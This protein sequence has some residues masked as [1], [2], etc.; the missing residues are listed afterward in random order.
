MSLIDRKTKL[1]ARRMIRHQKRLAESV[2][3]QADEE[4]NRLF[5][6]RFG[7]LHV[8]R[9]FVLVWTVLVLLLGLGAL[10]QVRGLN[11]FYLAAAPID[12]GVYREGIIGTFTNANPLFATTSVDTSVSK[13]IFSGLFK[14]S[15][16]G[17]LTGDLAEKLD[18]DSRGITYTVTL[19]DGVYW[20]DGEK[21]TADDVV[22]TY[23]TIQ[24]PAAR[25][26]LRSNWQGVKVTKY[27]DKIVVFTLPSPLSSF[28]Y[29]LINGIVPEHILG[30]VDNEDLRSSNFNT[31]KPIGTGMFQLKTLEVSGVEID[32]RQERIALVRNEG[33]FGR[34]PGLDSV[35]IR[36]YRDEETMIK[37]FD[38]QIIKSMVGLN[39]VPDT[40]QNQETVTLQQAPLTSTV[41]VFL[42]N[43][44]KL[45]QDKKLRQ[46]LLYAT[47]SDSMRK[48]L[49]YN[50]VA[51]D[52]P[53]LKNQ[54]A[55]N[56]E[57]VQMPYDNVKAT[58]LL[59]ELGW[60]MESDGIRAKDGVKLSL[61]F[62]SQSLSEYASITQK[63]QQDWSM[64]GISIEAILQPEAD[65]QVNALARH[66][67]DVFLYGISIG[68]DPDVFA[69]W[70]SS[71]AD[72]NS[73]SLNLSEYK[74][75]T[76]DIALEAGRTRLDKDLRKV[77]YQPFLEHW[78]DDAP[79]KA[80]YQPRFFMVTRGTFVG[81]ENG[82]MSSATD[83]Y[84]S[85]AD[86]KIRNADVIK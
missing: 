27:D 41:M 1:K 65:I 49:S 42:N 32:S 16:N 19:R 62:V 55:Y 63:L 51:S 5:F 28:S 45:L 15:G 36:S 71:Q 13:L 66:D 79:A 7:R 43:S 50:A 44:S 8:V 33:Y 29:S 74:D 86:W 58:A 18:V 77:K 6:R 9:R 76:S 40:L 64:L 10:W 69:Y 31:V 81:F 82:Y 70:H 2:S 84:R 68:Y 17:E 37:D 67:Y 14:I 4:L 83:R 61:K 78:R 24:N 38:G 35:I 56:P 22:F 12:G 73:S 75:G 11:S 3:V 39:S 59:D 57:I 47:D 21:F 34:K 48:S 80:L 23:K 46:A 20:Q 60:K 52:S 30:K 54:F 53:F 25:S 26:P 72:P 85:I